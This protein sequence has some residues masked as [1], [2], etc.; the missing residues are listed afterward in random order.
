MPSAVRAVASI[1]YLTYSWPFLQKMGFTAGQ[2]DWTGRAWTLLIHWQGVVK[3]G[4]HGGSSKSWGVMPPLEALV[5]LYS[6]HLPFKWVYGFGSSHPAIQG[7]D[8]LSLSH[9]WKH[10]SHTTKCR[11]PIPLLCVRVCPLVFWVRWQ[12]IL[13]G[14]F[15]CL[16]VRP[17]YDRGK[18]TRRG[19]TN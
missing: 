2:V 9:I 1:V 5:V 12:E 8:T 7:D 3:S 6:Q 14:S 16:D 15:I 4:P 13:I 19:E 18:N 10:T 17:K 11:R